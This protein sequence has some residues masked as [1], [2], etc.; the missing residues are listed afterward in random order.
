MASGRARAR[1]ARRVAG[2][3]VRLHP[4]E[5]T[6]ISNHPYCLHLWRDTR[7]GHALPPANMVGSKIDGELKGPEHA[8]SVM[9]RLNVNK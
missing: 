6:Y 2:S 7:R 4:P 8:A 5:S 3:R 9:R 1:T